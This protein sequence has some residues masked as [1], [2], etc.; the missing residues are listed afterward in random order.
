[1]VVA[2]PYLRRKNRGRSTPSLL[3]RAWAFTSLMRETS[4]ALRG[5]SE[6]FEKNCVFAEGCKYC[7]AVSIGC[8]GSCASW[9]ILLRHSAL[10]LASKIHPSPGPQKG[11]RLNFVGGQ[12]RSVVVSEARQSSTAELRLLRRPRCEAPLR[13]GPRNDMPRARADTPTKRSRTQ[14]IER[15]LDFPSDGRYDRS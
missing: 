7:H 4:K 5:K 11:V 8:H 2:F 1:M 6:F 9:S 12:A 13:V 14:K 3:P 15:R 10:S